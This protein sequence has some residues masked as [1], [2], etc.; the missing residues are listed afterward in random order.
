MPRQIWFLWLRLCCAHCYRGS[1]WDGIH[2]SWGPGWLYLLEDSGRPVLLP[3]GQHASLQKGSGSCLY[4]GVHQGSIVLS[5]LL[6]VIVCNS[7]GFV[8]QKRRVICGVGDLESCQLQLLICCRRL[9][10][11]EP[12]PPGLSTRTSFSHT[13][14]SSRVCASLALPTAPRPSWHSSYVYIAMCTYGFRLLPCFK[15]HVATPGG[16]A[17]AF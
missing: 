10:P 3:F 15:F 6:S 7:S 1:G 8:L 5:H 9:I 4:P 14:P 13:A 17:K 12:L 2:S 11:P 16:G